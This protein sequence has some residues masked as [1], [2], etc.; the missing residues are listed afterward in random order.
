MKKQFSIKDFRLATPF[1][2]SCNADGHGILGGSPRRL[3]PFVVY[4]FLKEHFGK[5]NYPSLDIEGKVTWEYVLK[6][7]RSRA[8]LAVYDWKLHSWSIGIK[9]PSSR[10][11]ISYEE[12][13]KYDKEARA[14]ANILLDEIVEYAKIADIPVTKYSYQWIENTHRINYSY[15]E[16]FLESLSQTVNTSNVPALSQSFLP[17]YFEESC[18]AWGAVMSFVISVEAMFNIIFEIY[19]KREIREDKALRHRVFRLPLLDKWLLFASL[20]TCFVEPLNRR[21]RGY[22]SLDRLIKIRNSW[23]HA[24]VIDEMRTFIIRKDKL[25]FATKRSPISKEIHPRIR[26]ANYTLA[27]R[28]KNDVDMI[29]LEILSAMK[30]SDRKKF[31]KAL[32]QDAILLSRKGSLVA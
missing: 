9:F 23:A 17:P 24:G 18:F 14:D 7:P 28:V 4:C 25:I 2:I 15:G 20:C 32:G 26:A 3:S 1:E 11:E 6:P 30:S 5:P 16:H 10:R 21:C 8:L 12:R 13:S 19:L 29:K 22:R 27:K 31:E